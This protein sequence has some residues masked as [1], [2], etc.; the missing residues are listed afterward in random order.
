MHYRVFRILLCVT[1]L[2]G[3]MPCVAQEVESYVY[4]ERGR[5]QLRLDVY[6]PQHPRSDHA[7]VMYLFGG[8]FREG[9]RNNKESVRSCTMLAEKGFTVVSIDYRLRLR[10]VNFDTVRLT[11]AYRLFEEAISMAVEDCASALAYV[12]ERAMALDIDRDKIILTGSSAGAITVLQ[13]DY[14]RAN[15]LRVADALPDDFAPAAI[16]SYA[17]GVYCR[18]GQLKYNEPPA[19]TCLVHGTTDKIVAYRRLHSSLHTSL[20]GSSSIAKTFSKRG[21]S[22][23]I[24]RF[25]DRGHEAATYLSHTG[26]EFTAFVDAALSGRTMFYDF[27]CEDAALYRTP[28][29]K[30]T[31]IDIYMRQPVK[32][33]KAPS[34]TARR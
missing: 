1:L 2:L 13:L 19:P 12:W 4:A 24:M 33:G 8:G 20:Y 28:F 10:T 18:N 14:C 30:Y 22:H 32:R 9:A 31:L 15:H 5:T 26:E 27:T 29:S 16:I 17:G 23:W 6:R 25:K 3:A 7:C 34:K 11:R 21:Y